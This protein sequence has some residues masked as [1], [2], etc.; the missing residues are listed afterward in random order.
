MLTVRILPRSLHQKTLLSLC[1]ALAM[2]CV[3]HAQQKAPA[4]PDPTPQSAPGSAE[5]ITPSQ[6]EEAA[7]L[8]ALL[9]ALLDKAREESDGGSNMDDMIAALLDK[10][11]QDAAAIKK[12]SDQEED[13]LSAVKTPGRTLESQSQAISYANI[14]PIAAQLALNGQIS[15]RHYSLAMVGSEGTEMQLN[16]SPVFKSDALT[17]FGNVNVNIHPT[18]ARTVET[19]KTNDLILGWGRWTS[20]EISYNDDPIQVDAKAG[21]PYVVGVPTAAANIPTRGNATY[22]Y[23][24]GV[25]P[26]NTATGERG[27]LNGTLK[28]NF[29]PTGYTVNPQ[30]LLTM[31]NAQYSLSG[32]NIAGTL[33]NMASPGAAAHFSGNAV[34]TGG[35]CS[36]SVSCSSDLRGFLVG[37]QA[38]SAGLA[39]GVF[40]GTGSSPTI[41]G[42][43]GFQR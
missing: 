42:A 11:Q 36:V 37:P 39:Y 35:G 2:P 6:R 16:G 14:T 33:N 26:V 22:T 34:V 19:G 4:A 23:A 28:M 24:G 13:P 3:S 41:V 21:L 5:K 1:L 18:T 27:T 7:R 40:I 17:G 20:G 8:R 43:G 38:Q 15:G 9:A 30:L 32:G 12:V 10:A 29:G 31:S 25:A